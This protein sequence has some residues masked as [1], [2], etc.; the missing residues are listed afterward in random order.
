LKN[1]NS[2]ASLA[3]LSSNTPTS[4]KKQAATNSFELFKKQA[5]EREERVKFTLKN[6]H[7]SIDIVP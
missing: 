5:Q 4:S 1:T 7:T 3:A 6:N 2:W